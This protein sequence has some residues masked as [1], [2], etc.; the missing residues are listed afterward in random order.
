M[1]R[2]ITQKKYAVGIIAYILCSPSYAES[3]KFDPKMAG[4]SDPNVDFSV[5]NLGLQ[6][7]GMYTVDVYI[8]GNRVDNRDINFSLRQ[9][10]DE[11]LL[12]PCLS[13]EDL[14]RYGV[15]TQSKPDIK[16]NNSCVDLFSI[17]DARF[18]F[19]FYNQQLLLSIPQSRMSAII[20]GIAP[21]A[22][23]DDGV[24]AFLMNYSANT[25]HSE[26][27]YQDG[28]K[29]KTDS[30]YV[31]LNPGIN[32]GSWRMR[33]QTNWQT[34]SSGHSGWETPYTYLERG[35]YD[36]K[37]SLVLGD[38]YTPG[39]V[40][41]SISFR[42]IMLGT[43]ENM[44]PYQLRSYSPVITG[45]ARTQA[46]VEVKQRGYTIYSTIVPP[47]PFSLTDFSTSGDSGGDLQVTVLETDGSP[48][49]FTV[50]Y[51]TPAIALKENYMKYN[52]MAG[53]YRNS[54]LDTDKSIM[55]QGTLMYGLPWDLTL[56]GGMQYADHYYSSSLGMGISMGSFGALSTDITG[57]HAKRKQSDTEEG[58]AMRARYSK[59]MVS[60]ETNFTL[61]AYRYATRGFNSL[62]QV[63]AS[64]GKDLDSS[65]NW[66]SG[67]QD[68]IKSQGRMSIQQTMGKLGTLSLNLSANDY[69]DCAGNNYSVGLGYGF[70]IFNKAQ[71]SFNFNENHYN[72]C[73]SSTSR[74][75]LFGMWFSFP[76]GGWGGD[77]TRASFQMTS[78]SENRNTY[79]AG[80]S[81]SSLNNRF[82]WDIRQS[83]RDK[84]GAGSDTSFV[85]TG[86]N[87]SYGQVGISH[88]YSNSM[89]QT[90]A[91]VNGGALLYKNGLVL[92]QSINDA[93]SVVEAPGARGVSVMG[94]NGV[95]TD[96]RG[97][98][99]N[100]NLVPYQ[101]NLISID[102]LNI[103]SDAEITQTDVKVVPTEGAVIPAKFNTRVGAKGLFKITYHGEVVPLGGVVSV[104]GK[105][106]NAGIVGRDG[107]AYLTGLPD[108]G[109]L[110]VKWNNGNCKAA[111]TLPS[112]GKATGLQQVTVLC[113]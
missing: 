74:D 8:N 68:R 82:N 80:L 79:T 85:N 71:T 66:Y 2:V 15:D 28:N 26:S 112:S 4:I 33:S 6:Q 83:H 16:L 98:A 65:N 69:W 101:E 90:S 108:S 109:E 21:R 84:Q 40:F 34:N 70:T 1:N 59:Y 23:W 14:Y 51:Q 30:T 58:V 94:M 20:T 92:G 62:E 113:R 24:P 78:E 89:R 7:P 43:N 13:L 18:N 3:Y 53:Q 76:L 44:T 63:M 35:L 54:G 106:G 52:F 111:Y 55:F 22:L 77:N 11:T 19:D 107:E 57:S 60:T 61:A 88:F 86:W 49:F 27:S 56:Y 50:P 42:G 87:G 97:Y 72:S 32:I 93:V 39:D 45:I 81:G 95:K 9:H 73:R 67:I 5:F 25:T 64:Y 36:I 96:F 41:D 10:G 12:Y 110:S 29:Q 102:P 91:N 75:R 103:S 38:R 47:G 100:T 46:R 104:V 37:S 105:D 17:V 48:Q 31:Q 99:I